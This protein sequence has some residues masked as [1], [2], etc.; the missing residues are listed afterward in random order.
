MI[1]ITRQD[2]VLKWGERVRIG[3]VYVKNKDSLNY[4]SNMVCMFTIR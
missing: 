1:K 3:R 2:I 4:F